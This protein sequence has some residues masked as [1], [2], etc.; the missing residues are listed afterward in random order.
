MRI[1]TRDECLAASLDYFNGDELAAEV[2]VKKYALNDGNGS[3]YEPTPRFMHK[4]LAREFARIEANY[5]NPMSED[6]IFDLLDGFKYVV[7]QGSPMSAVG[8]DFQVQSTSNCFVVESPYDSYGGILKTDQE[9]VQIAKR[10]GGIGFDVSTIRPRGMSANNAAKTTDGI[11]VFMERYSNST[12]E[13]AQNGRRGALMLTL[14]VHHPEVRTFI[15]I[16]RDKTKVTGANLSVRLSDEFLRAVEEGTE[17]QLRWPVDA[18]EPT[19]SEMI[20]ARELWD[21]IIEN[22]WASAEPG[23]LFWDNALRLTPSDIYSREGY[24]SV[25]TNPCGEIVLS[26]YDSCR[27][28]LVNL[29]SF[30]ANP[31][32]GDAHFDWGSFAQ[33]VVKAQRLMD[34]LIDL[35]LEQIDKIL[36][37]IDNDPEPDVVKSYE[38]LLW[39]KVREACSNGRRTGLGVTAVGDALAALGVRYGSPES[40]E[41]VEEMYKQLAVNSYTSSIIMA[42]E[43]G[44]FPICK[45]EKEAGHT[46]I[47]RIKASLSPEVLDM[48]MQYGRRNIANTTTA[49][50]GSVSCLTQTTSGIEPAYMLQYTR[51]RKLMDGEDLEPDYV[52]DSGDRWVEY[53]VYHHGFQEWMKV[54]GLQDPELSPYWKSTSNDIDW[55]AKVKLQAGAQRWV[56]HAISNTT[57][58]PNDTSPE[59]I[60]DIYVEAWKSGCKG[61]T[62]YRDGCRDGV[63][64]QTTNGFELEYEIVLE[65]G[66][67]LRAHDSDTIEYD[68]DTYTIHDLM[69]S[70]AVA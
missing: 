61:A 29:K 70:L 33:V 10:R 28:L 51:R 40:I 24:G 32:T 48:Y 47:E 14:S 63:L 38:R 54:T 64:V 34:D 23:L 15:N 50:A 65:D 30:V 59:L 22:A 4:R 25:S 27:L 53:D 56:C 3:Y 49:P 11:G 12:R 41:V 67:I 69:H 17:F 62:V 36:T 9:L 39:L 7:P 18:A 66:S 52:D 20:D 13:V 35:E 68:G 26:P 57:N 21:E 8:N 19:I 6:E 58:V 43:R 5:P 44:A 16:K 1:F 31:Y 46:F 2:F 42:K 37:K 60:K 45:V 55:V